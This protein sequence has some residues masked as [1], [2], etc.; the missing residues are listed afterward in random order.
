M[1]MDKELPCTVN[2]IGNLSMYLFE[3]LKDMLV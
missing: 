3:I 1:Q 2:T